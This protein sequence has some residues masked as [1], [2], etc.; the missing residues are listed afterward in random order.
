MPKS[1]IWQ[2]FRVF[3]R[4][5]DFVKKVLFSVLF[6]LLL[7]RLSSQNVKLWLQNINGQIMLTLI[8]RGWKNELCTCCTL[9]L[10]SQKDRYVCNTKVAELQIDPKG[11]LYHPL[12]SFVLYAVDTHLNANL[13]GLWSTKPTKSFVVST[14]CDKPHFWSKN[15]VF[16]THRKSL[17]Q[18]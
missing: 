11:F 6:F 17:I 16:E 15:T 10:W 8:T 14:H 18:W 4:E 9:N 2:V 13:N 12:Q 3:P 1:L 5:L 7:G